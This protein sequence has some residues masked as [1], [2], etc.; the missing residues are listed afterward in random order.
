MTANRP[1]PYVVETY[2]IVKHKLGGT[3]EWARQATIHSN[4]ALWNN[5]TWVIR[6]KRGGTSI[7][8]HARG[9]AMDLSWRYMES[10]GNG[11][12]DGRTKAIKFLQA[13]LDNWQLL[14]IQ[15]ILDY[16]PDAQASAYYGRGW[17]C[18]RVGAG[19]NKPHAFEA[20]RKYDKPTIHGAPGGDWFH[21]ELRRDLAENPELVKQAFRR[22]FSTIPQA[23]A[24]V[25]S[26]SQASEGSN[27][28][29]RPATTRRS[30]DPVRSVRRDNAG[31]QA[32]DGAS[33]P[34]KRRRQVNVGTT[35]TP[36]KPVG[37]V[38]TT[39]QA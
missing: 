38:G 31:R 4:G 17:R 20:W 27:D 39:G 14:G 34:Q 10:T 32:G 1:E 11:V 8:N 37:D 7:S 16:W 19:G 29:A 18:D 13:A 2:G 3:E 36:R 15:L 35:R 12:S 24:T 30:S 21:I 5:G 9:V 26:T 33:V 23:S 6:D 28:D 22:A 25:D